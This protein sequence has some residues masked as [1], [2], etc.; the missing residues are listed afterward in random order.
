MFIARP[1]MWIFRNLIRHQGDY[2]VSHIKEV[3]KREIVIDYEF[4]FGRY[5]DHARFVNRT[6]M[7]WPRRPFEEK[8]REVKRMKS[9]RKQAMIRAVFE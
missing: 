4:N 7:S 2:Y 8:W 3:G 5:E 1:D 6:G 9:V